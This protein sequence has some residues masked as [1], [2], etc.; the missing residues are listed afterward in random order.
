MNILNIRDSVKEFNEKL[1][2][3][4]SIGGVL[5]NKDDFNTVLDL[6]NNL[7]HYFL[8]FQKWQEVQRK[9]Q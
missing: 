2:E 4:I 8:Y 1:R 5:L 7:G 6:Y 3:G 9:K